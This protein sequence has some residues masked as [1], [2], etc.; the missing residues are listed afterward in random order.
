MLKHAYTASFHKMSPKH[1]QRHVNECIYR[2]NIRELDL[3]TAAQM[4]VVART[5]MDRQLP[6]TRLI[7]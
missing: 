2:R 4:A 5:L 3:G 6:Y 7:R 1:L